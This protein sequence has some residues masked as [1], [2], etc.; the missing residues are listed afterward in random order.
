MT[1]PAAE[2]RSANLA[3]VLPLTSACNLGCVF[4]NLKWNPPGLRTSR[5]GHRDPVTVVSEAPLAA[6]RG[7]VTVGESATRVDEGEPFCHPAALEILQAVRRATGAS[8]RVTTNATLLDQAAVRAL[9][10]LAPI[11]LTVS[12]NTADRT[13]RRSL[14]GDE[15]PD[16]AL[17]AVA[18]LAGEGVPFHG[19]LVAM[20]HVTGWDDAAAT[21]AFLASH[22]ARS[23]RAFLPGYTSL[24]PAFLRHPPGTLSELTR[25][26]EG[27][28]LAYGLPVVPEPGEVRDLRPTVA[29]VVKGSPA[30]AAGL[31]AG[32]E[33]LEVSGVRPRCRLEAYDLLTAGTAPSVVVR[34]GAGLRSVSVRKAP[35]APSGAVFVRDVDM[36]QIARIRRAARRGRVTVLGSELGLRALAL[37]LEPE[38]DCGRVRLVPVPSRA[39]GGSIGSAGLLTTADFLAAL[40]REGGGTL[41]LPAVAYGSSGRDL[42]GA[43]WTEVAAAWAGRVWLI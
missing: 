40:P 9:A 38:L 30:E 18:M 29:G 1:A 3:G 12:L 5:L 13:V 19:S 35:E 2:L 26:C 43:S 32:D 37:A 22:G 21:V 4:C 24:A 36:A 7:A 10:R 23:I 6:T 14:L 27:W 17:E 15:S 33:L 25:R 39:F 31:G 34:S 28:T 41:I 8:L 16:R 20:P 11:E 42:F